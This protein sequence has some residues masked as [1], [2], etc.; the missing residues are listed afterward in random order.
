MYGVAQRGQFAAL[1]VISANLSDSLFVANDGETKMIM[2]RNSVRY[3][4]MMIFRVRTNKNCTG[5]A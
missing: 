1:K 5:V 3:A 4:N 2:L